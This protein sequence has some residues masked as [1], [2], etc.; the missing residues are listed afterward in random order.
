[1]ALKMRMEERSG[2][3]SYGRVHPLSLTYAYQ[4]SNQCDHIY[5]KSGLV[6]HVNRKIYIMESRVESLHET[7]Q[8]LLEM[9]KKDKKY[10]V[11]EQPFDENMA[12]SRKVGELKKMVFISMLHL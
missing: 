6:K 8:N 7:D 5:S 2:T 3:C 9:L 4:C 10:H 1:M 11:S 12:K